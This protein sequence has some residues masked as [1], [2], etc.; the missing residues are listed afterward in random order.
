MAFDSSYPY[1]GEAIDAEA[2]RKLNFN[3]VH[4]I[5]CEQNKGFGF[6]YDDGNG[7][8]KALQPAPAIITNEAQTIASN[9]ITLDYPAALIMN[10]ATASTHQIMADRTATL[11]ANQCQLSAAMAFGTRPTINFHASTSGTVYVS[12]ITQAWKDVW[13]NRVRETLTTSTNVAS[14]TN[15]YIAIESIHGTHAVTDVTNFEYV[16]A[17]DG[18]GAGEVELDFTD[19]GNSN[20]STVSFNNADSITAAIVTGIKKPASGF[21]SDRFLEDQD[22]TMSSGVSGALTPIHPILFHSTCGQLPDYTAAAE[23]APHNMQM[24]HPHDL[25]TA[26]Q[27]V[28]QYNARPATGITGIIRTDDTTSDAVSLSYVWGVPEEIPGIIP[29]EVRNGTDLRVLT[30]VRAWVIGD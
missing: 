8:I 4:A 14:S 2:K 18:A 24:Y 15:V 20:L 16:R 5:M 11:G 21:L 23:R 17:G 3:N 12:Y 26:G 10:I 25:G 6:E 22:T 28:I 7:K 29:L 9:A 27:F 30:A 1:G 19:A 13:D